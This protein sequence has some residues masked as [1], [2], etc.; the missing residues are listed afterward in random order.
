MLILVIVDQAAVDESISNAL[1]KHRLHSKVIA[2]R[3]YDIILSAASALSNAL[4]GAKGDHYPNVPPPNQAQ[5]AVLR[6][7][8]ICLYHSLV[9]MTD[10]TGL[11]NNEPTP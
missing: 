11:S 5:K 6:R 10:E 9:C 8:Q 2:R 1:D 7:N 4:E 3:A